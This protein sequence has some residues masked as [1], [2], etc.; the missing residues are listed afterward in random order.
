[1][2]EKTHHLGTGRWKDGIRDVRKNNGSPTT[3]TIRNKSTGNATASLYSETVGEGGG[4]RREEGRGGKG[5]GN[6]RRG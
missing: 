1:M 2:W 3:Y 6:R 4:D 5:E